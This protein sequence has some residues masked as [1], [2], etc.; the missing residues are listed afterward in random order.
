ML[1]QSGAAPKRELG[2]VK[3]EVTTAEKNGEPQE[4]REGG[5]S[6][7]RKDQERNKS[8]DKLSDKAGTTPMSPFK[9]P[10]KGPEEK[11]VAEVGGQSFLQSSNSDQLEPSMRKSVLENP[12]NSFISL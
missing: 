11:G 9:T 12:Y 8:V 7:P 1:R 5:P 3:E 4:S 6:T 10:S 2:V